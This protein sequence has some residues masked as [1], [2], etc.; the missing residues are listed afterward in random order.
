MYPI[1]ASVPGRIDRTYATAMKGCMV[2]FPRELVSPPHLASYWSS[3]PTVLDI[4]GYLV[5]HLVQGRSRFGELGPDLN[6]PEVKHNETVGSSASPTTMPQN[7]Y[8]LESIEELK[9]MV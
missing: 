2:F 1:I 8:V 9:H 3:S 6:G 7:T 5:C 4:L